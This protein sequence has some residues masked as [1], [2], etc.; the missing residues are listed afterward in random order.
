MTTEPIDH[1]AEARE[2]LDEAR[3]SHIAPDLTVGMAQI[4]TGY[5]ALALLAEARRSN[6]IADRANELKRIEIL[7]SLSYGAGYADPDVNSTF[8]EAAAWNALH[9]P[10]VKGDPLSP[11]IARSLGLGG[12]SDGE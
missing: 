1:A 12:E 9:E 7:V 11:S 10:N 5:A 4:G 6:D 8:A 2:L 3:Q